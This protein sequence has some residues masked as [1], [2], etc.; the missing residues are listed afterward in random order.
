MYVSIPHNQLRVFSIHPDSLKPTVT[1][2]VWFDYSEISSGHQNASHLHHFHQLDVILDGEFILTLAEQ[3][4]Q[5]GKIGD[6]WIVPPLTWHG[7][8]CSKPFRWCSFKFHLAPQLWPVFGTSFQRFAVSDHLRN[9]IE[10]LGKRNSVQM[11]LAAE[12][13]AAVISLCLIEFFD[14]RGGHQS[15]DDHLSEFRYS[16]WPLLEKIQSDPSIKWSVTHMAE[17]F[18]LSP[19]H[20]SRCFQGVIGQTPQRYVTETAMRG[21]AAKLVQV[22]KIPIKEIAKRAGYASVY[23]FTHAFTKIFKVSPAAYRQ[24]VMHDI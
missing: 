5:I 13:A 20:F 1:E 9:C 10:E 6:A 11:P 22:P 3:S 19:D 4:D 18:G 12:H 7:V 8:N 24:N 15:E 2:V 21:A 14:Q 23:S 16:L 17:K